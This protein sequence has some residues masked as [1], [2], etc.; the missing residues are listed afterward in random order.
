MRKIFTTLL[1]AIV[2]SAWLTSEAAPRFSSQM[3]DTISIPL[4]MPKDNPGTSTVDPVDPNLIYAGLHDNLLI[5]KDFTGA[6]L[7]C[8][9]TCNA[10]TQ[11][12]RLQDE[13]FKKTLTVELTDAGQYDL[14]LTSTGWDYTVFGTFTYGTLQGIETPLDDQR[15]A[16]KMLRNGQLILMYK[17]QM[18][19]VQG[20]QIQ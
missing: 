17:G 12:P 8:T 15:A 9:L 11:H 19:N 1:L 7:K 2:S 13:S 5:V 18:Y 6:E 20:Q 10:I 16:T 4:F 14:V 3:Q